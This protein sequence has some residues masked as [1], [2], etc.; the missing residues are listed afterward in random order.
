MTATKV[1]LQRRNQCSLHPLLWVVLLEL[2]IHET[3]D[4]GLSEGISGRHRQ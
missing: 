2:K 3:R 4:I 1:E